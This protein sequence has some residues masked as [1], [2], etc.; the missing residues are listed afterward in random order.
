MTNAILHLAAQQGYNIILSF[1]K[2]FVANVCCYRKTGRNRNTNKVHLCKISPLAAKKIS[3]VG[4]SFSFTITEGV[5]SFSAHKYYNRS[6]KMQFRHV[7][8]LQT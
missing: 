3:H 7:C 2:I 5:N 8:F 1:F 6:F 4:T